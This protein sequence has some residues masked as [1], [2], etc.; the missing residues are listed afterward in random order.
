MAIVVPGLS[1]KT[2][3]GIEGAIA[4][5]N[6]YGV[7]SAAM[8]TLAGRERAAGPRS[9]PNFRI[10]IVLHVLHTLIFAIHSLLRPV[11]GHIYTP[12]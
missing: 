8:F 4:L 12:P 11:F 7:I 3:V 5:S 2:I 6:A 1:S 9:R 10:C